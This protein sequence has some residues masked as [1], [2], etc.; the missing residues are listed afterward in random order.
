M[1]LE[2]KNENISFEVDKH[3]N[4]SNISLKINVRD[5][6][7]NKHIMLIDIVLNKDEFDQLRESLEIDI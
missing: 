1:K 4:D 3:V 2:I 6:D 5:P 7:N